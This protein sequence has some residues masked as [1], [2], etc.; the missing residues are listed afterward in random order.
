MLKQVAQAI[1]GSSDPRY[2]RYV[3]V[4]NAERVQAVQSGEVDVVAETMTINCEREK[5]VDFSTVYYQAG[6]QILVPSDSSITGP[7]GSRR[8]AGLRHAGLD[9]AAELGGGGYAEAHPALGGERRDR[10]P[11]HAPAGPGRCHQHGRCDSARTGGAGPEHEDGGARRSA[12]SPTGWPSA[13]RT[14]I[15]VVRE[16]GARRS[17]GER[18]LDPDLQRVAR[19]IHRDGGT[20]SAACELP[21]SV[22]AGVTL[23]E[24]DRRIED[25]RSVLEVTTG[26]LV[27]STPTSLVISSRP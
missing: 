16:R 17:P 2:I 19:Q 12:A 4:P 10:L 3:I 5:S 13:R 15:H 11:G 22:V 26:R 23:R 8:E 24:I 27:E 14:L 18:D 1:F 9:L 6:Q 7:S 25:V 21:V 20:A